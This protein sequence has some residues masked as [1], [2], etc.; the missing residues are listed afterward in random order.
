MTDEPFTTPG[1]RVPPCVTVPAE[2]LFA[3][4][5]GLDRFRCEL[6]DH[7]ESGVE[8][9]FFHNDEFFYGRRFATR[10]MAVQWAEL[11]RQAIERER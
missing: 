8:A 1:Y 10:E 7:G 5:R 9:Q 4:V 3:F 6:R 11:E 2:A